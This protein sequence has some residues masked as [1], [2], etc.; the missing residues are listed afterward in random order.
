MMT[1]VRGDVLAAKKA[2]MLM[3][4]MAFIAVAPVA[5]CCLDRF[6]IRDFF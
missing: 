6:I 2:V 5:V 1:P 3:V 4:G